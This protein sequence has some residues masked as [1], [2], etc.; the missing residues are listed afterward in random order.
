M[1]SPRDKDKTLETAPLL[2]HDGTGVFTDVSAQLWS[3]VIDDALF[4]DLD[5]D[6]DQNLFCR[7]SPRCS[8]S[9]SLGCLGGRQNWR[10]WQDCRR[11]LP[12]HCD[13]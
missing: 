10:R 2:R 4:L 3:R 12:R 1:L 8:P 7:R 11:F 6:G 9:G 5:E 13:S